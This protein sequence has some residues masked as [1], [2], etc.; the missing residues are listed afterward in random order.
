MERWPDLRVYVHERGA[1]HMVDPTRLY[2]SA[3]R[4]YGDDMERLWGEM[5]PVPEDRLDS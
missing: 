4:L 1:K 5:R 2:D 3:R